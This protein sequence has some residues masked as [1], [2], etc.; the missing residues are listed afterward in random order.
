MPTG[1]SRARTTGD[2]SRVFTFSFAPGGNAG[3]R[4]QIVGAALKTT[5]VPFI[6]LLA[7]SYELEIVA[8]SADSKHIYYLPVVLTV[9]QVDQDGPG[10]TASM[11]FV[12]GALQQFTGGVALADIGLPSPEVS[13]LGLKLQ[14]TPIEYLTANSMDG[15][16][17]TETSG[18]NAGGGAIPTPTQIDGFTALNY[19]SSYHAGIWRKRSLRKLAVGEACTIK[20]RVSVPAPGMYT[21]NSLRFSLNGAYT[22]GG[23]GGLDTFSVFDFNDP[24]LDRGADGSIGTC[25]VVAPRTFEITVSFVADVNDFLTLYLNWDQDM[26]VHG[27]QMV[28]GFVDQPW[29]ATGQ[30]LAP[31]PAY[32]DNDGFGPIVGQLDYFNATW[33]R[34]QNP[35]VVA[36][37]G[38]DVFPHYREFGRYEGNRP[39][40]K[41]APAPFASSNMYTTEVQTPVTPALN[42]PIAA[43]LK[44]ST[45]TL[46]LETNGNGLGAL[47][48]NFVTFGATGFENSLVRSGGRSHALGLGSSE[49]AAAA[50]SGFLGISRVVLARDASGMA[51]YCNGGN[52]VVLPAAS[53]TGIIKLA[54]NASFFLRRMAAWDSKLAEDYLKVISDPRHYPHPDASLGAAAKP[55]AGLI[56]YFEDFGADFQLAKRDGP[57]NVYPAGGSG[58]GSNDP[59]YFWQ[60]V[61]AQNAHRYWR[62]RYPHWREA[63]GSH[64]ETIN[65]ENALLMDQQY[66]DYMRAQGQW[67]DPFNAVEA[68]KTTPGAP[69]QSVVRLGVKP[70]RFLDATTR[71]LIPIEPGQSQ[72]YRIL[73]SAMVTPDTFHNIPGG[74]ALQVN[75]TFVCR[76]KCNAQIQ[77]LWGGIWAIRYYFGDE[78]DLQENTGNAPNRVLYSTH[79]PQE[80]FHQTK[81]AIMPFD[82][83]ADFDVYEKYWEPGKQH[84]SISGAYLGYNDTPAGFDGSSQYLLLDLTAGGILG[85]AID[86]STYAALDALAGKATYL[87]VDHIGVVQNV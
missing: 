57:G 18:L 76:A 23:G 40:Y 26:A 61:A 41:G 55:R 68:G 43:V 86:D 12:T 77:G 32:T 35:D 28:S 46:M 20:F 62:T 19:Y 8:T 36:A 38:A 1:P 29:F 81:G 69:A 84:T 60:E 24:K 2:V 78:T 44:S 13:A 17:P 6:H 58:G 50:T 10:A 22:K 25:R 54:A 27:C 16:Q 3:G 87:E 31:P 21:A 45:W 82:I 73:G 53:V 52:K 30:Q 42:G 14:A 51:L 34:Q 74:P 49:P 9:D 85:G 63:I 5:S 4:V 83:S 66:I 75:N 80:G 64:L 79:A 65:G 48:G 33:Y 70:T 71:A 7:V 56:Q 72:P 11:D 67:T 15:S 37:Y 59:Y 47:L 39:P